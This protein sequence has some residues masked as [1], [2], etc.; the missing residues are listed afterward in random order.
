MGRKPAVVEALFEAFEADEEDRDALDVHTVGMLTEGEFNEMLTNLMV[1]SKAATP[2]H[3]AMARKFH[4]AA[5]AVSTAAQT[6]SEKKN[7]PKQEQR[8][9]GDNEDELPI[10]MEPSEPGSPDEK[11]HAMAEPVVPTRDQPH[12]ILMAVAQVF[13]HS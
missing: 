9:E 7:E 12:E 13:R 5:I 4:Q 2:L 11:L 6:V 1:N 3:K 10:D 8:D